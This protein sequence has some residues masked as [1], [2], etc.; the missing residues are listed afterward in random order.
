MTDQTQGLYLFCFVFILGLK[1]D[2]EKTSLGSGL[3]S[4][5]FTS[6]AALDHAN[7]KPAATFHLGKGCPFSLTVLGRDCINLHKKPRILKKAR[8]ET[9]VLF[10]ANPRPRKSVMDQGALEQE[11]LEES[12]KC[13]K[14][15]TIE[16]EKFYR[17]VFLG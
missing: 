4:V 15:E 7:I 13:T 1:R 10:P 12:T 17:A 6:A 9:A 14:G 8:M 2:L 5:M 16:E 11:M 3:R